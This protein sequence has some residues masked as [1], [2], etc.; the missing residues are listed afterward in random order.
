MLR[1]R[2]STSAVLRMAHAAQQW[3]APL[4]LCR[5]RVGCIGSCRIVTCRRLRRAHCIWLW[6]GWGQLPLLLHVH[7][8]PCNSDVGKTNMKWG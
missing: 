7:V 4:L 1:P 5:L 6:W 2:L 8:I 3:G